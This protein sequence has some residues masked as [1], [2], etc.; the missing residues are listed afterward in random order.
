MIAEILY[1][2]F[3]K[4][5]KKKP[6]ERG[7]NVTNYYLNLNDQSNGD[8]EVYKESCYYYYMYKSGHNFELLG[9]FNNEIDAVNYA[10]IKHPE[11]KIDGC[12][13]CCSKAHRG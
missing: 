10:K 9:S 3:K 11:Y 6:R 1:H 8:Y 7:E 12:A 13:H 2:K 5:A 4:V